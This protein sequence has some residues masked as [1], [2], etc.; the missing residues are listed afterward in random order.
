MATYGKI[1]MT[2]Y[3]GTSDEVLVLCGDD[4]INEY[5]LN[6]IITVAGSYIFTVWYKSEETADITFNVFGDEETVES[7]T[8]WKK[9]VKRI[10]VESLENNDITITV[11]PE[12]RTYF[13]E[14]FCVNGKADTSWYPS[15]L[16]YD[17]EIAD[18]SKTATN[19]I[20]YINATDG[21]K[22]HR[23]G[24][25]D[26][27]VQI[28]P[29]VGVKNVYDE[30]NYSTL[31]SEGLEI[32]QGTSSPVSVAKFGSTARI[33]EEDKPNVRIDANRIYISTPVTSAS[34]FLLSDGITL[35]SGG[36]NYI[37]ATTGDDYVTIFGLNQN[38]LRGN[39][40]N[41]AGGG[42]V[43]LFATRLWSWTSYNIAA[44]A[45]SESTNTISLDSYTPIAILGYDLDGEGCTYVNV[46]AC[47]VNPSNSTVSWQFRNLKNSAATI[48]KKV[49]VL[50]IANSA[51]VNTIS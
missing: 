19:Y 38:G 44:S 10:E 15:D 32:F 20:T 45:T 29:T 23:D 5:Y 7:T 22:V 6:N 25:D 8:T 27:Y 40:D 36:F 43:P 42:T 1:T 41:A 26:A 17:E 24:D 14:A 3:K 28:N 46:V 48:T 2:T 18:A 49:R 4:E 47:I 16:D 21:I 37:K 34:S 33:G 35:S 11:T 13:Y 50:Y 31:D 9:Y 12:I 39:N 51:G 30:N